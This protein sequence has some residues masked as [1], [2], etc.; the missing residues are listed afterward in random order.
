[1]ERNLWLVWL[2]WYVYVGLDP[3]SSVVFL[4]FFER[5]T[6]ERA[7]RPLLLCEPVEQDFYESPAST[8]ESKA[9]RVCLRASYLLHFPTSSCGHAAYDVI[10]AGVSARKMQITSFFHGCVSLFPRRPNGNGE[11]VTDFL[12]YS[13]INLRISPSWVAT[14]EAIYYVHYHYL[15]FLMFA[16]GSTQSRECES[17]GETAKKPRNV[18]LRN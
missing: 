5:T 10:S 6:P 18:L 7:Y 9:Y 11:E 3:I 8:R 4:L 2:V 13:S 12:R 16:D 15:T 17:R 14:K 1:M